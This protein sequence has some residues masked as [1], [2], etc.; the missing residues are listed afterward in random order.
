[1]CPYDVALYPFPLIPFPL[2]LLPYPFPEPF[3]APIFSRNASGV[4]GLTI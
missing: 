1:L 3:Y 4:N 2:S